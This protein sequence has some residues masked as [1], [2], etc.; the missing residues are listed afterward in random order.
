MG[1][2]GVPGRPSRQPASDVAPDAPRVAAQALTSTLQ[3]LRDGCRLGR[4]RFA[5]AGEHLLEPV[6]QGVFVKP[7]ARSI[8]VQ[9]RL[10]QVVQIQFV[11]L[12]DFLHAAQQRGLAG[13]IVGIQ[14][15]R[16]LK[17]RATSGLPQ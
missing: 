9:P 13:E 14:K 15:T 4:Q 17:S 8:I 6:Q 5:G 7:T 2:V 1:D 16:G 10:P 11:V 12:I 3:S